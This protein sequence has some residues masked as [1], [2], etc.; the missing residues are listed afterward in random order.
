MRAT[1][2]SGHRATAVLTVVVTVGLVLVAGLSPVAAATV[3]NTPGGRGGSSAPPTAVPV[4]TGASPVA[5]H[6]AKPASPLSPRL[7][8]LGGR[9]GPAPQDGAASAAVTATDLGLPVSGPGSLQYGSA[10]RVL[11]DLLVADTGP[12]QQAALAAAG[13]VVTATSPVNPRITAEVPPTELAALAS[14][15]GVRSIE[16]VLTPMVNA[17]CPT[18]IFDE[19]NTQ[20]NAATA[21]TTFSTAGA[22][23]TVGVI[24]DSYDAL[25][26]A[27]TDVS[28]AELP[29]TT[30]PCGAPTPVN[31]VADSGT[32]DEG[33]AMGQIIHDLA[34]Q[35][36]IAF[37]TANGGEVTFGNN[38]RSLQAAGA[39]VIVDDITYFAEPMYQD[40]EIARA[41]DDVTAL[42]TTY[43]S[44]AA[45]SNKVVGGKSVGSYEAPGYR[46]TSCPVAVSGLGIVDCH[47]FN[48][49][50]AGPADATDDLIINA[51]GQVMISFGWNE[52]L[53]GVTTDLD[54]FLL[55]NSGA[56]VASST[57][58][59]PTVS[60][61]AFEFLN[62]SNT[63]GS[64]STYRLVV[65][66]ASGARPRFKFIMNRA[67][68]VSAVEWNTSSLG[69]VVGP[70]I[71]GHNA[72][73]AGGSIAATPYDNSATIEGFSSR[74]P[75]QYCFAP[76]NGTGPA[77][78][79]ETCRTKQVDV[80]ATDGNANSFFGSF[81]A[82]AFRFYGTSS[83][84][85]HAAAVAALQV[86]ARPC[87]TPAQVL[88]AQRSS[89]T[90]VAGFGVD[91]AGSGLVDAVGAIT[92]LGP[93]TGAVPSAPQNVAAVAERE[94]A[95]VSWSAPLSS[96]GS[97]ITGYTVT[98][99]PGGARCTWSA[100]P[101]AC[102]LDGLAGGA[103]VT[104]TVVAGNDGGIGPASALSSTVTPWSGDTFAPL[105]PDR[106]LDSRGP[107]G[108]WGGPLTASAPKALTVVD[109]GGVPA[110]ASAV[111]M[112]VTV[113]ESTE[114][115]FVTLYPAGA[116]RPNA[117][118]LNFGAGQTI[119]NLVTVKV[120]LGGQVLF[121]TMFGSTH[122]VADVVGYYDD[123]TT[124]AD[125]FTGITP[126]RVLDSRGPNGGWSGPI[127]A[128]VAGER[129]LVVA[130]RGGVPV[131]A[132]SVVMNVTAT[133][134]DAGSFLQV[135]PSDAPRPN[136]SN[137]N[138]G[139]GET[140]PNLVTVPLG[141]D[142]NVLFH[143]EVGHTDVVADVVGYFGATGGSRF[144]PLASPTRILD[145]RI[146]VGLNGTWGPAQSRGLVVAGTSDVPAGATAVVMN[147]TVTNGTLG[148]FVTVYPDGAVRPISSNLNFGV[149]QT[150][151]NL[152]TVQVPGNGIVQIYNE[153]GTVDL[154]A[155][156]VGYYATS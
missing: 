42:G 60:K 58:N 113:T 152:V 87:R 31:V 52:P 102:T 37:A 132:T 59:N 99:S 92:A 88:A 2:P 21:R 137:V 78:A 156:A 54:A 121:A 122:V 126:Q 80:T 110:T 93:C 134:S 107:I 40:G 16:E 5:S 64:A 145:D 142:G 112:N 72:A 135:W 96:G 98:A 15:P 101:L 27:P 140:I 84:A 77:A 34:P 30:N 74:G 147:M 149:G 119:P 79:Y 57:S 144:H 129:A 62:F 8:R 71:Y 106:L 22:G 24:S 124:S 11:V 155:D 104:V 32:S 1:R 33:R 50:P 120:G 13:A 65:G 44:S 10:G 28:N 151:P 19:G 89:A 49:S 127:G 118:N 85:P 51:G 95:A 111:I 26:G 6:V 148:S 131:G 133:G 48:P 66:R 125:F 67:S 153:L 136:S 17:T 38:I 105:V 45:N 69:D 81:T 25:G 109:V 75:A 20:L 14:V 43:F 150:I 94:S 143:N 61:R 108:G 36:A 114:A 7:A 116:T 141:A 70:T 3:A 138:F 39:Q 47:D 76:V 154:V 12:V 117:S 91:S 63:S 139:V 41:V 29:G 115:S 56:I 4:P 83:A 103:P 86:S 128:G 90:P 146:A 82:G 73:L 23:V 130:G 123:G 97:A 53:F 55:D 9:G 68:G 18:G 46:P 100:G 35:A